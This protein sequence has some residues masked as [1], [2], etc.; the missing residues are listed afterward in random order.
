MSDNK[1]LNFK[2]KDFKYFKKYLEI[3]TEEYFNRLIKIEKKTGQN[4]KEY[5]QKLINY[6][7]FINNLI[8]NIK[9]IFIKN[10]KVVI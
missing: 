4:N 10:N 7:K 3:Y 2:K 1:L 9:C 6:E 5:R 8:L